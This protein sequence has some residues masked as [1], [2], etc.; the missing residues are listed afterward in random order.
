[1]ATIAGEFCAE[2]AAHTLLRLNPAWRMPAIL[3]V[4]SM[5]HRYIVQAVRV[6]EDELQK[7]RE[8][9]FE[10]GSVAVRDEIDKR[11]WREC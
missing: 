2:T 1:M 7:P 8:L 10:D 5:R 9:E 3:S 4:D 6:E 11:I